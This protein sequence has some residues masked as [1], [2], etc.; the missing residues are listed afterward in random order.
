MI[1]RIRTATGTWRLDV[2]ESPV[3]QLVLSEVKVMIESNFGVARER[4]TLCEDPAGKRLLD[5]NLTLQKAK[6]NANGA[7]V[8]L[9]VDDSSTLPVV[10]STGTKLAASKVI[11][12]IGA[13]GTITAAAYEDHVSRRGFRPGLAALGDL[14]KNWTLSDFLLMDDQYTFKVKRQEE[15]F[16]KGVSL[17]TQACFNF[18][19]YMQ[20]LGWRQGRCGFLYGNWDEDEMK[21]KVEFVYEPEQRSDEHGIAVLLADEEEEEQMHKKQVEDDDETMTDVQHINTSGGQS[22]GTGGSVAATEEI[23]IVEAI[24]EALALRRVGF[25]FAHPP[26]EKGFVFS[27]AEAIRAAYQQLEAADGV[28]KTPFVTV[29]VTV[30]PESNES[31]F[32]A[33]Q[34]SEQCMTMAAEGALGV[35]GND[36][37]ACAVHPTFTVV[38]EGKPAPSVN[39]NF[40]LCNVP[41][42]QHDSQIF[43]HSTFPKEHRLLPQTRDDL[44]SRIRGT[45]GISLTRALA[46]FGLILFL[47][48]FPQIFD[49][50]SFI[51]SLI[52]AIKHDAPLDEGYR[53]ILFSFAG[54]DI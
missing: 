21:V 25:V 31:Q 5:D 2:G 30:D 27:G 35:D 7:M 18:Q 10:S 44:K 1:L 19:S 17:D 43:K 14:K 9:I 24:A 34:V 6:L 45:S 28:N 8:F 48:S 22:H 40:F 41:V 33:Y 42:Q 49:H 15:A 46:D 29:K 36:L 51:P 12:K 26:R 20:Q 16:C 38:V 54:L 23:N 13:D 50:S 32:E 37:A 4:Q 11:K 39:A 52:Q 53:L 47:A 3:N